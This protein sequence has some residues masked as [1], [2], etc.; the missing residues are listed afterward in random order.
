M[1][2]RWTTILLLI[3][4]LFLAGCSAKTETM[5]PEELQPAQTVTTQQDSGQYVGSINSD[6][7]HLPDCRW[8]HGGDVQKIG[9]HF[10]LEAWIDTIATKTTRIA[11]SVSSVF[12]GSSKRRRKKLFGFLLRRGCSILSSSMPFPPFVW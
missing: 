11:T 2:K 9:A 1:L 3:V 8:A 4:C 12:F 6:K 7:Y 5:S 10:F